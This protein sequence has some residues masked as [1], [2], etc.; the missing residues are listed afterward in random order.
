MKHYPIKKAETKK[1]PYMPEG[2]RL[3]LPKP[4]L[5][6]VVLWKVNENKNIDFV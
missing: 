2:I 3:P 5:P 1:T 4:K 6:K